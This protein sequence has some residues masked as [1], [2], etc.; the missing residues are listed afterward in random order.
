[1]IGTLYKIT[2]VIN[3]KVYIGKTYQSIEER[4]KEHQKDSQRFS[5]RPLYKAMRKY[6]VE[7]FS[8]E[9]LG[10]YNEGQLEEKEIEVIEKYNSFISGYN[11]TLGGDGR[12]RVPEEEILFLYKKGLSILNIQK[13]TGY[14][15]DTIKNILRGNNIP[16]RQSKDYTQKSVIKIDKNDQTEEVFQSIADAARWIR[17]QNLSKD[18]NFGSIKTKISLVCRNKRKTAYGYKWKWNIV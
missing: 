3:G 5:T 8:I 16:I 11:A 6:G 12:R 18:K 10:Q 14:D 4:W 7:N 15:K 2:N 1:M 17:E 9:S 13:Q